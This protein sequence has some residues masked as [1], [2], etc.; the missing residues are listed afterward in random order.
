MWHHIWPTFWRFPSKMPFFWSRSTL[1]SDYTQQNKWL[2]NSC[3]NKPQKCQ[4]V[5]SEPDKFMRTGLVSCG[6]STGAW[7][8]ALLCWTRGTAWTHTCTL[9]HS[10]TETDTRAHT[11]F[12]MPPTPLLIILTSRVAEPKA[13]HWTWFRDR[14]NWSDCVSFPE[15]QL[16][17][18]TSHQ[19]QLRNS[20]FLTIVTNYART[21]FKI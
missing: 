2:A 15:I 18:H 8:M 10:Q 7:V 1:W 5:V 11:Q 9:T 16:I 20:T 17:F 13:H 12:G 6:F 19:F 14:E 4:K 3:F 21:F